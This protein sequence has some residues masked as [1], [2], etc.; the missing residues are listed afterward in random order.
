MTQLLQINTSIFAD[1]GQSSGLADEFVT[2]WRAQHPHDALTLRDFAVEPVPHLSA[3]SFQAFLTPADARTPEQQAAVAYSDALI[4]EVQEADVIVLGL[5]MYNFGVPSQLKAWIDH[6][7]RAGVTFKYTE[8]GPVGLLKNKKV[9]V[10]AA[11]GGQYQGT[12]K[13]TQTQYLT[14][15]FNF[16]G[17]IDVTFVYAEGL[18]MGEALR[19]TALDEARAEIQRLAA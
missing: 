9:Y 13:D 2:Q 1:G 16:I 4:D 15:F 17:I 7:A 12:P 19:D 14:D 10:L 6:I 8:N 11:R 5:P 3:A 18:N